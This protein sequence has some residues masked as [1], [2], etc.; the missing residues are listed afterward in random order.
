[1]DT[2]RY[3][4]AGSTDNGGTLTV[5]DKTTGKNFKV[6]G[7]P[8]ITTD[9]EDTTDFQHSPATFRLPDGT[10]ITVNPTN[11]AGV[12]TIDNVTITKGNDAVKMTGFGGNLQTQS[13]PGQGRYL[14]A[15][16]PDGTVLH[17]VGGQIDQLALPD[18]TQIQ[19][20]NVKDIDGYANNNNGYAN[21]TG[22]Q[23]DPLSQLRQT[24]AHLEQEIGQ[25]EQGMNLTSL[26]TT[27]FA[28]NPLL[29]AMF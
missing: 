18:G 14:D 17:T 12:N 11:N 3:T 7:D 21:N 10:E 29:G 8:H 23:S 19:G 20:N 27:G 25:I 1:V 13:L 15:T 24:I 22:G 28:A 2:G 4:I 9:K 5:T 26:M 16:T 6:W